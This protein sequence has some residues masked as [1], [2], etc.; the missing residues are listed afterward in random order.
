M[1]T[2]G[3]FSLIYCR[4][5]ARFRAGLKLDANSQA[6]AENEQRYRAEIAA[7]LHLQFEV[8][9]LREKHV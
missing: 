3:D 2:S 5:I 6:F 9:A 7:D 8:T 1:K 4:D